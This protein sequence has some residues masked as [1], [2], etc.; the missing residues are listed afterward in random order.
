M[1]YDLSAVEE[2]FAC[3]RSVAS[4]QRPSCLS[5]FQ[6][7][8]DFLMLAASKPRSGGSMV[9]IHDPSIRYLEEEFIE[10]NL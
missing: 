7:V 4:S 6:F 8:S 5:R 2:K 3:G 1:K 10:E 9:Q